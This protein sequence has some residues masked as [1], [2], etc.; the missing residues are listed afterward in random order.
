MDRAVAPVLAPALVRPTVTGPHARLHPCVVPPSKS[1]LT[2][3]VGGVV[4]V[5]EGAVVVVEGVV[6]VVEGA[7]VVVVPPA[8]RALRWS[9][10]PIP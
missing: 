7:V 3:V 5:V 8:A 10:I 4:V 6:V 1:Y 2:V 9:R